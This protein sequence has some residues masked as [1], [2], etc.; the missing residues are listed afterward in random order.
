M[1]KRGE[2][3]MYMRNNR[4]KYSKY[5]ISDFPPNYSGQYSKESITQESVEEFETKKPVVEQD[6]IERL[7]NKENKEIAVK[8][9]KEEKKENPH[10]LI[11][12]LFKGSKGG[13]GI[14]ARLFGEKDEKDGKDGGGFL[15]SIEL[16]DLI[17][18]AVIFFLLK[19]GVEDDFL[20]ILALIL[21]A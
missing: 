16:E 2:I 4:S 8:A 14:L 9:I 10:S 21:L 20:I 18:L 19:D 15:S 6:N 3:K 5:N 17:L 1:L 11:S 7:E 12:G 13:G